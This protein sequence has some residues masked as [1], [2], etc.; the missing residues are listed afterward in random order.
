M[1]RTFFLLVFFFPVYSYNSIAKSESKSEKS[2]QINMSFIEVAR[3]G[4]FTKVKDLFSRGASVKARNRFGNSAILLAASEGHLEIVKFLIQK[5]TQVDLSN[6]NKQTPLMGAAKNG[7][8]PTVNY[9]ISQGASIN[10]LN[11]RSIRT[12]RVNC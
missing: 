6:L 3:D 1:I 11:I 7:H 5:K 8:L 2:E 4:D 12:T 10:S 9:L